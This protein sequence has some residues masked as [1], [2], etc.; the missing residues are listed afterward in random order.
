[1]Q[2][3]VFVASRDKR[4]SRSARGKPC[5]AVAWSEGSLCKAPAGVKKSMMK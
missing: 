1:M 4:Q 3:Y 5:A 2:F